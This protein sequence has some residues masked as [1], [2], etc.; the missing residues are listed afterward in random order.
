MALKRITKYGWMALGLLFFSAHAFSQLSPG[1]LSKAH[2]PLEGLNNC[3]KCHVL[4]QKETTANCLKCHTE[5]QQLIDKKQGYHASTDVKG[6]NCAECHGEHFGRDFKIAPLNQTT[7]DHNLAGFQLEG[8]H[9]RLNCRD[10][11]KPEL[12]VN[13]ISQKK[14]KTWLGLGSECLSCHTNYHQNTLSDNCLG[15][16][17]QNA[18][19]PAPGFNHAETPY[20]LIGQHQTV[21]CVGCHKVT[22]RNSQK[23]QQF[24]G[25]QFSNCTDCHQDVHDNK[26]GPDCR[27]CHNEFSF[28]TLNANHSFDHD[29]TNYPLSGKHKELDCKACHQ[30]SLTQP[31]KYQQCNNCHPDYH[32]NQFAQDGVSPDCAECHAVT[33]F[34]PSTFTLEKHQQTSFPLEGAHMATP[35]FECHRQNDTW[36]FS[37]KGTNCTHCHEN[38]HEDAL[39]EKYGSQNDCNYCHSVNSWSEIAFNHSLTHFELKD[40][41]LQVSCSDCHFSSGAEGTLVQK[42][43]GLESACE[44]CHADVH[45]RQFAQNNQTECERCHS[46]QSWSA[47]NFNH[48]TARFKLEGEHAKL[49]CQSCHKPTEGLTPN[50]IVYK[51]EDI[52]C[53]SCH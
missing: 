51:F 3:T 1:D 5:I 42:F 22:T 36:D 17:D 25:I 52:S 18:F 40:R 14:G 28:N 6:K 29:Q 39:P 46:A 8:K 15:C 41:H 49:D 43:S 34:S 27:K 48:D 21:D 11:H 47:E 31:L 33:G 19:R 2:A 45:F 44:S 7:F 23:F 50:Y 30:N 9:S 35:C 26:F 13:H 37:N 20:P 16:H 12:I 4:G 24:A 53:A 32:Q 10:C 38:F